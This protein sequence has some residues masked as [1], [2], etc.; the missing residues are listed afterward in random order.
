MS[1][2]LTF[3]VQLDG[4]G[5]L[6][7][8]T[9]AARDG[10]DGLKKSTD[11]LTASAQRLNAAQQTSSTGWVTFKG[12]A[13][14]YQAAVR[15]TTA[16]HEAAAE[17]IYV[18]NDAYLK[19]AASA[20]KVT[21]ATARAQ[22]E[23]VVLGRELARGNFSRL[24][25]TLSIIAQGLSP[26][27]LGIFG[28]TAALAAGAYAW[29]KW[30]NTAGEASDKAQK[31]LDDATKAADKAQR[32][33]Q[34]QQMVN[35]QQQIQ[36]LNHEND[37]LKYTSNIAST[38]NN[39]QDYFNQPAGNSYAVPYTGTDAGT[40]DTV[41]KTFDRINEHIREIQ[42]LTQQ[43]NNL[44]EAMD[45]ADARQLKDPPKIK[46]DPNDTAV[47]AMQN[48]EFKKQM[49]LLGVSAAQIKVY[50]L[51]MHGATQAQVDSAQAAA[52]GTDAA[53]NQSKAEKEAAKAI[54][55]ATR[56]RE[57][58]VITLMNETE[59]INKK[60]DAAEMENVKIGQTAE[61]LAALNIA[62]IDEQI[63][64]D[65]VLADGMRGVAGYEAQVN[66][67]DAQIDA[68]GRLRN[69][70]EARPAAEEARKTVEEW[71][72]ANDEIS[73]SLS[74]GLMRAFEAGK[75]FAQ[76]FTDTLV[77]MFK[78]LVLRPVIQ[79]ILSPATGLLAAAT[80]PL[81][82]SAG[83]SAASA[84][85]GWLNAGSAISSGYSALTSG[86]SSAYMSAAT[87]GAGQALGLSYGTN[88]QGVA[89]MSQTGSAVG[90][91]LGYVGAG[92]AG[93]GI[94]S[95]IAGNRT[96]VGL[97]GTSISA[98]GAV[99]G[100]IWGPVGSFVGGVAGGLIDRVFGSGP[101]TSGDT[102]LAG[103]F[104][105]SG[106][107]GNYLTPW[108]QSGGLFGGGGSGTDIT[109]F[110]VAQGTRLGFLGTAPPSTAAQAAAAAQ[111]AAMQNLVTGTASVFNK[112]ITAS[113]DADKSL[114]GWTFAINQQ[115][116]TTAQQTQLTVDLA[117]S[118][119]K[120]LIPDLSELQ[121][122]GEN[123]ADTAV[124]MTDE[125]ILTDKIAV[126][127]GKNASSAFG[128]AGLASLKMR[129]NLVTLMGGLA[130]MTA[131]TQSYYQ[132]FYSDAERHANDMSTLGAQFASLNI[133]MPKSAAEFRALVESQNLST[134][135]GQRMYASLMSLS[136]AFA[137]VNTTVAATTASLLGLLKTDSFA[138]MVDYQRAVGTVN[139]LDAPAQAAL[140][141]T[142]T[143]S[144]TDA[145]VAAIAALRI[146]V[147]A[148]LKSS[149]LTAQSSLKTTLL[150]RNVTQDGNSL[151]TTPA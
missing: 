108:S 43:V 74:D 132:N 89:L 92:L 70:E 124:R 31:A 68:L 142:S 139:N 34:A 35:L 148:L 71:K 38:S 58:G 151:L 130:N 45:K 23:M 28:V 101:K 8:Q 117:N 9:K 121:A 65:A 93:I 61:Q 57:Q 15:A 146:Q 63:M 17:Q 131:V 88:A 116:N 119:G 53:I 112:L 16:A 14:A 87:S 145:L 37:I 26:V 84:A 95:A 125:F 20:E 73:R 50:E 22:Q 60:A 62:R 42:G 30:G 90:T 113:G 147:A 104:S 136:G 103:K 138:S 59:Q 48:E 86:L 3:G 1:D 66:A 69:A 44:Q 143:D 127:L 41:G 150:L 47:I 54:D 120:Y 100:S 123:L 27:A 94:G 10:I 2:N 51:A 39:V 83:Q 36:D 110:G 135:A 144:G 115:V 76:A 98:I 141:K 99:I 29:E 11:D 85:G 109:P 64:S 4:S 24:P 107:S 78:T 129:D 72:R 106:F 118:M 40:S 49:E 114:S 18:V 46:I 105:Q 33:T 134:V 81:T 79:L 122:T 82:A 21:F 137:A 19:T 140:L 133:I 80:A 52:Q 102:T 13:D 75:G 55:E 91:G 32:P 149:E 5:N 12:N 56:L 6:V 111:N 7:G 25:G 77:N 67:I 126:L 128:S 96:V 97:D